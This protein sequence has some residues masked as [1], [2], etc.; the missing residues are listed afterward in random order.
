MPTNGAVESEVAVILVR[1]PGFCSAVPVDIALFGVQ[2]DGLQ[3]GPL[4]FGLYSLIGDS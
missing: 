2:N 1:E 3:G 4:G